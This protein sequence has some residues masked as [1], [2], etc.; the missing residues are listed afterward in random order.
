[1][2]L[3]T[4]GTLVIAVLVVAS[5]VVAPDGEVFGQRVAGPQAAVSAVPQG[6]LIALST[7]VDG[8]YEQ[9]TVLDSAAKVLAVYH[10][11]LVTGKPELKSVR[12]ISQD[13]QLQAFNAEHPLPQEIR[14]MLEHSR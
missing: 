1:M 11:D 4:L 2:K 7:V 12:H 8:Q 5:L 13:L 9:L 3:A 10:I 6:G 14:S